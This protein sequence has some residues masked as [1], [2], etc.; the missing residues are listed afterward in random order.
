MHAGGRALHAERRVGG[1]ASYPVLTLTVTV[2]TTAP[3]SVTNAAAVRGGGETNTVNDAV[4]D[5]TTI[6]PPAP[7]D[8][9]LA[10]IHTG[11]FTQGQ[12]GATYSLT[13]T[14]LA[15]SGLTTGTVTVT[16]TVP[17][18]LTATG[19]A[20]AGWTCTQPSG[21]CTRGDALAGGAIYPALTLTVNGSDQCASKC[22][23]YRDGEW[24]RRNEYRKQ[25][26]G[27]RHDDQPDGNAV[28]DQ[29][30]PAHEQGCGHDDVIDAGVCGEQ[31]GGE[32]DCGT[33]SA[34]ESV[35]RSLQ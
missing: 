35:D 33:R 17:T 10:K 19:I 14:N 6:N 1:G 2:A 7:A 15:G 16:D 24:R 20:G 27:R 23:E 22:N 9:T 13:V 32:L 34:R 4:S 12:V 18:G 28:D 31:H 29:L 5:A 11:T 8:L 21:P 30:D 25:H 3:A 26:R